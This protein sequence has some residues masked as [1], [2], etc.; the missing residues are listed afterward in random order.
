MVVRP[1]PRLF[2]TCAGAP[3]CA[4]TVK[5]IFARERR[6]IMYRSTGFSTSPFAGMTPRDSIWDSLETLGQTS[7][8]IPKDNADR[9][10]DQAVFVERRDRK[11]A[12][13]CPC[14]SALGLTDM[15]Y[16]CRNQTPPA[17]QPGVTTYFNRFSWAVTTRLYTAISR[18][19]A[20]PMP[21]MIKNTTPGV[22]ASL[23][24]V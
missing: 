15:I 18:A 2:S 19:A 20:S 21:K 1:S 10:D 13:G 6:A 17:A 12:H 11:K 4:P 3:P 8:T 9:S 24:Y 5:G 14:V 16:D 7:T 22:P 23:A